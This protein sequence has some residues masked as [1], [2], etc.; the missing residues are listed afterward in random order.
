MF[1][2]QELLNK[3]NFQKALVSMPLIELAPQEAER[4][5]DYI[6]D[7]S[8]LKNNARQ[9]KMQKATM[10]IRAI[11]L[12]TGKFLHPGDKFSSSDYKT[13]LTHNLIQLTA[14]E[15][16]GCA[17]V[18]DDDI[19]DNIEGD[20]F[21]DHIMKMVTKQIA[22]ELDEAYWIGDTK[23]VGGFDDD[24]IRRLF[25]GWRYRIT[26]SAAG[27]PT[28]DEYY[29]KVS[30]S[31]T[32]LNA[33]PGD[34]AAL[35]TPGATQT[36]P[37]VITT[38]AAHDYSTGDT[39]KI[40]NVEGMTELNNKLYTITVLSDTTFSLD[41]I[42]STAYTAWTSGGVCT[43]QDF[44]LTGKIVEQNSSPPY[45]WEFKFSKARRVL[46][47][48]YK[49]DGLAN[50]RYFTNDQVEEDYIEAI[51]ARNTSMGDLAITGKAPIQFGK[52]PIVSCPL[53]ANDL[54]V[55][56]KLGAGSY[57]DCLLTHKDNLIVGIYKEIQVETERQAADRA[58]YFYYTL[59]ADL[60]VENVNAIVLIKNLITG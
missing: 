5:Q 55:A 56:G 19:Q 52:I 7:Q 1:T 32:I 23:G 41:S 14:K 35:S 24:D 8:V 40:T 44:L 4:F 48:I 46:P 58:T 16:R 10:N 39:I 36:D 33:A 60:A 54:N 47:A 27:I 53:M 21:V 50:L 26:H 29:N 3:K 20:A 42:D 38:S 34:T 51:A 12:G 18:A 30:G 49:K 9:I 57:T 31:A 17:V 22:N 45:N 43:I 28:N 25:D 13:K 11:G 59:R 15:V 2:N 37:C 6:F